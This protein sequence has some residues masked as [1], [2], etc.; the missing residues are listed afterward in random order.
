MIVAVLALGVS[1]WT[2]VQ[3]NRSLRRN[4]AEEN[5]NASIKQFSESSNVFAQLT[6]LTSLSPYWSDPLFKSR[7]RALLLNGISEVQDLSVRAAIRQQIVDHADTVVLRLLAEQNRFIQSRFEDIGYSPNWIIPNGWADS[8]QTGDSVR[9]SIQTDLAWNIS[10]TISIIN[11]LQ[12]IRS[13]DLHGIVLSRVVVSRD[14]DGD[15]TS[16]SLERLDTAH[17]MSGV[18]FEDVDLSHANFSKMIFHQVQFLNVRLDSTVLVS[19]EFHNCS[20]REGSSLLHFFPFPEYAPFSYMREAI[21]RPEEVNVPT[22][23]QSF[24]YV[25]S[26]EPAI[27]SFSVGERT[28]FF[29][30]YNSSWNIS[31]AAEETRAPDPR[32][33][34]KIPLPRQGNGGF[35]GDLRVC[36]RGT[37]ECLSPSERPFLPP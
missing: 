24:L 26:F 16:Y 12:H 29:E 20:F 2:V 21:R 34:T 35:A 5:F 8:V 4:R 22:W 14:L 27:Q 25:Q 32:Y 9:K 36:G 31:Q 18:I 17:I 15:S 30:L 13:L 3:S 7:V 1:T 11:R 10:I 28:R 37:Y 19:T 23:I 6:A 33:V